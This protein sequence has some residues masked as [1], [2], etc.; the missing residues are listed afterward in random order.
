MYV[1]GDTLE[2]RSFFPSLL[3]KIWCKP[4]SKEAAPSSHNWRP[5]ELGPAP[6]HSWEVSE[7]TDGICTTWRLSVWPKQRPNRPLPVQPTELPTHL[8]P[9]PFWYIES[10]H[11]GIDCDI[12]VSPALSETFSTSMNVKPFYCKVLQKGGCMCSENGTD[13]QL[14][15]SRSFNVKQLDWTLELNAQRSSRT[16]ILVECR[17]SISEQSICCRCSFLESVNCLFFWQLNTGQYFVSTLIVSLL[18]CSLL[19]FTN[20]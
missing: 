19:C 20:T 1:L 13:L 14:L 8:Q 3:D 16:G 5:C 7:W 17:Y 10:W 6:E 11:T 2:K 4:R 18:I 15:L 12:K 9:K